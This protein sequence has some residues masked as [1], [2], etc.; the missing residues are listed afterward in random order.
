MI[1]ALL[2]SGLRIALP[3]LDA[4][5]PE[6]LNKI[7]SATGMPVEAS[8]L[9]ASWQNFGPTLEAH[10]IRA[11]LKDGGEFSVKRVTLALDVW[12]SLLHMRWQFRDLTFWQLRFRTNT[13]ITSGGSDDSLEAS[14]ISDLFLRQFD[15]FDLRDSEVSFLTPSGQRAELAIPQLTWLNDPRRHR[16]EGLVSLSSLT[17]QHG[18]MQVRMDL[19]DD[20]G[21]LSNGRVWLQAD[22]IDLKPWLGKWMQ[23]NI[24]LETAQFSLEG[25]M[26]IDKGDVTGGD[27]WL[28]QGGA[29]WLGEKQTHTLSVDNLTAHITRENPG[30]QFSIPDTRIT[31]DGKPWPSGALT[32]AWIPEQDV[33]GKD[34]K[35]S[36]ELRIRASNLELAGLEGIR[37]LAAKL[38]PAL[39]DVW[40][41][42]QPSGKIN[43]LALDIPLQAADK[44]RF[45]ASW[46]DLAWKQW[47]LLPGAEHF[48]GT[49]SGSVENGLLTASMKQAK[50]PYETVFR[51]PLEIAD[52][53]AT[54]SWLNNNKGFQLDGRNIDVKAKAVHARGGFR[55]LQPANDEPWLGI[56]AGISTDDGSQAWR[57]FPENLM[58]KDLVDYLSGA[59]QGGEAD[60]ATLVYGGNPQLFPYKHNEGQFE[61]LVPLRNAKFAFQPDWPALTNLDIELDFI[62]DGLWMKTDG[63]NLGGVRASNLTAV[64]PDYS[65]EK[66]L[67]D[68]DIKG[69]GKAVGPYFDET[70]LKDSLGATLQE[71]QLD[72]DV[73]ARL[74]LDIPLNGEL[75]TAKGEVTLRNNSLFIKPLASTLK[76]LSGKFS[77]INGDLQS[78]PLTASWFN[79]PLNV[80]FSTKEGAK[81]YQ[82]AV[83]LNGNWQPAKT[84]VLPAAVNEALSGSVAWDGKVGIVLPYHAGAT[85]NVELN[86]DLKNVSSHLPSP[87]AKPAGEPLPV[88]VKVDG[89]LNSFDLTGQAGADNHFNSRWLLGQ[90]LTLDRAIWAADSKTLPPLPEQSGV[91]LNMPPMNGAEWLALFQKGAA[92]SVGGAASFPQHITLR[93][94]ML[95]LGNQQWNNLSI[96]SQPTANGTQVEA[97]GR[98]IN[99]T[100][101]M[102][103]NAPWLANIKYL[104]YNP[105]VAKTRGDSTPSSP[106]P[107]TERI[108]FRGWPDAQIRCAECWF[109][110]QK[111]GRIDSDL[112]ISGDTL[113]LTNGLIDTGFSRLT[114]DG[115]WVNNPGNE[116]TS[117]K[118]KLRGQKIDAAA[119]FFGVTTPIRQSSFNVDYDL[120][121]RKAPWQ[122]DEATLNGI[123]HTQ[124]GK[125]EITEIN[126][127]HAGQL[128]RLLSVD[129]LMRKLR[130]D[131]RDTFGEGF[132]FD[133][134]RSTA[135][136]KDGVMHTDDTLV[137]GLEADIAMKGS[138]NLVRRDLN[139]E[140]VVAPEISATVGVAADFAV[141]PIVG[142]AVFAASKVLGP[143]W[144]KVSILRYHISGP[145]D[146]PQINEVLRQPRKEKAQ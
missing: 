31:M 44:T 109:W 27:V 88:N 94:P 59:I 2:V 63:V 112:T 16:A 35:R 77:F 52:G 5:R 98:E 107:T 108:N 96:V 13:P 128:L 61:V 74:H 21:L 85:Y 123:I 93:T 53:Q 103:N 132:Y 69:P 18:V 116:R 75:V 114:A 117:L 82:V 140:A 119:E 120:H 8:Q 76:N 33:G 1:A 4:W 135:W 17:G 38:S 118:G 41:S 68:A 80:D 104:Y 57:Y 66:L 102:R 139:M 86:G 91:E 67:I 50:M 62:N 54:I 130:F 129:A 51:A 81:A 106:F 145:L 79:Q 32:L 28:K 141:N 72:G 26:T 131:F 30:W 121:W 113:T 3:H 146:D 115:E 34:N 73:N 22:D 143:L 125:G 87:L 65:K 43:T 12:Q 124:L 133:S 45:Q 95:S 92:E 101:A 71:L 36:D 20:E 60:N 37:P 84:G 142:A 134:I 99:A 23:D 83:N 137:D 97:Q 70:P 11:E 46:S 64:I 144:S 47:K 136:I 40:R 42:T 25:W 9:S 126:T 19:R 127:G 55:Y 78:E 111:F 10:D 89:N 100:L 56:L 49:L 14:H 58:D 39:G 90:K 122:P 138:V 24:A 6:I 7:E 29:S 15:H 110:G 105:S 48:S